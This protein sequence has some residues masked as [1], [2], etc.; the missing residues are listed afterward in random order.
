MK[1]VGKVLSFIMCALAVLICVVMIVM[2]LTDGDG[3]VSRI[4]W[5]EE[6]IEEYRSYPD[7]FSIEYVTAY[8]ER[9][10]TSDGYFSVSCGR[11]IPDCDQWQFTLR[12]NKSTLEALGEERGAEMSPDKDHFTFALIDNEGRVYRDF[13]WKRADKGRYTYYRLIFDGIDI[14]AA[15]DVQIMIYCIDDIEGDELPALAV[16]KLPLYYSELPRENY[17]FKKELPENME[18]TPGFI[19]GDRLVKG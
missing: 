18:P 4:A 6:M 9:Y 16:G 1:I 14:S 3:A 7:S 5:T 10:F 11:Y 2:N 12:Y 8:E 13:L 19:S 17:D 15:D